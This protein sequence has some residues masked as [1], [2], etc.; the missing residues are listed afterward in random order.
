MDLEGHSGS[1]VYGNAF[2]LLE[3][4]LNVLHEWISS[5]MNPSSEVHPFLVELRTYTQL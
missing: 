4:H 1:G 2:L 5:K 3:P